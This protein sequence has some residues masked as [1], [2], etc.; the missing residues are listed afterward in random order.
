MFSTDYGCLAT[1]TGWNKNYYYRDDGQKQESRV[2]EYRPMHYPTLLYQKQWHV[3]K[4]YS[5]YVSMNSFIPLIA[6]MHV[7]DWNYKILRNQVHFSTQQT[8]LTLVDLLYKF[9]DK[10][11]RKIS[12]LE[13]ENK[14]YKQKIQVKDNIMP[15]IIS[16]KI[17]NMY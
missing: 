12:I 16:Q 11:V 15:I 13:K 3:D 8:L 2:F 9:R 4:H 14:K 6:G 17:C 5:G 7:Y 10:Q 1:V